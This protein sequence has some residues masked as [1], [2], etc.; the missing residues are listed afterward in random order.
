MKTAVP[1]ITQPS[2]QDNKLSS[3]VSPYVHVLDFLLNERSG[4][5]PGKAEETC[6][7]GK[8]G[9]QQQSSTTLTEGSSRDNNKTCQRRHHI[10]QHIT[11]FLNLLTLVAVLELHGEAHCVL[12]AVAAPGGSHTALHRPQGLAVS[13]AGLEAGF[14][15]L[16]PDLRQLLAWSSGISR[17][18]WGGSKGGRGSADEGRG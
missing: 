11:T 16:G 18:P 10:N 7:G 13:V 4:A 6:P 2:W 17:A 15:K 5:A 14:A 9:L 1:F 8:R 12:H 3:T